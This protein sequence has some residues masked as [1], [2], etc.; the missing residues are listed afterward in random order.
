MNNKKIAAALLAM[1]ASSS[2]AGG[3]GPMPERLLLLEAGFAYTHSFYDSR[4]VFPES[5]TAITP[6]GY[7]I[8]PK[9]FYPED[10]YGGYIGAS[11][12][13]PQNWLLNGRFDMFGKRD[14]TNA[15]A[16]TY[17]SIAPAKLSLT[18]DKVFGDFNQLSYGLGAGAVVETTNE[19]DMVVTVRAN[20][21]MSESI[22]GRTRIDPLVEGF[23]MYRFDNNF[24]VKFNAAYQIPLNN[25]FGNG[26]LNLNLGVNYAFPV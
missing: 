17:I 7:A 8:N 9:N 13:F 15:A 1:A 2:Y 22:Q 11:L 24:G 3:M 12:Y 6:N 23:V 10:F 16:E 14:K 19:G 4:V 18:V 20:N 25:K 5:R 21:P 26:D